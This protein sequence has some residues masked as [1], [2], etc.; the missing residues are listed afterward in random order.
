M[1]SFPEGNSGGIF[2]FF[3]PEGKRGSWTDDDHGFTNPSW[4]CASM[5]DWKIHEDGMDAVTKKSMHREG[6]TGIF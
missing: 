4:F 3:F 2:V 6:K 5:V 1:D